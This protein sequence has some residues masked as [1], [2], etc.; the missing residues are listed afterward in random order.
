MSFNI[1]IILVVVVFLMFDSCC[2]MRYAATQFRGGGGK[3]G[4]GGGDG[5]G[6]LPLSQSGMW[7]ITRLVGSSLSVC[8]AYCSVW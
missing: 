4:R 3:H 7:H 2:L 5:I 6:M 1:Q 8:V